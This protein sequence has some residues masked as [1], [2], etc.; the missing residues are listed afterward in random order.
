M[1]TRADRKENGQRCIRL[2]AFVFCSERISDER[3]R[4]NEFR[5]ATLRKEMAI[6][7][8]LPVCAILI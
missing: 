5:N 7:I 8:L 3:V 6:R 1:H 4:T 2:H